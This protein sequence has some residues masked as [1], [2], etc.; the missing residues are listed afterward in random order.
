[1]EG[2]GIDEYLFPLSPASAGAEAAAVDRASGA[3]L[4]STVVGD[5][6]LISL[7]RRLGERAERRVRI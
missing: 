4:S 6:L 1:M 3:A 2:A 5:G 7:G